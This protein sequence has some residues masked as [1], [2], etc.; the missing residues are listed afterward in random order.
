[1]GNVSDLATLT[2]L[3]IHFD[4]DRYDRHVDSVCSF[5]S[6]S[7]GFESPKKYT[8]DYELGYITL[9]LDKEISLILFLMMVIVL[10]AYD[11]K[12]AIAFWV[13][14]AIECLFLFSEGF[15]S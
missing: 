5:G 9:C 12:H 4:C 2:S 11:K 1:M 13:I 3:V 15:G 6:S 7:C 10:L 14:I 8:S